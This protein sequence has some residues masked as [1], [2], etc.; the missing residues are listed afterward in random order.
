[1]DD[2]SPPN[3]P[4][5]VSADAVRANQFP[6]THWSAVLLAREA[7]S[8]AG[9]AALEQ[10]CKAYW[11]P[12][13][14]A[15]RR[16]ARDSEEARDLTQEFFARLLERNSLARLTPEGGRFR[17]WLLKAFESFRINEWH[18]AQAAKRGG[19]Q[20]VLALD[21]EDAEGRA[22][23]DPADPRTPEMIYERCWAEELMERVQARLADQFGGHPLGFDTLQGFLIRPARETRFA[24]TAARLSVT[25]AAL[26][27]VV[28]RFRQRLRE[29]FREEVEQTV[30]DP[31][32]VEDEM[33]HLWKVLS[34]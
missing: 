12:L 14:A 7:E 29:L 6:T 16:Q 34:E 22:G 32:E 19:G 27:A 10:L 20:Q 24:E 8:P 2:R 18:R 23:I 15:A 9:T 5:A 17:S 31:R 33:R 1:M 3:V 30:A 21:W 4:G 13:Y 28:F 11:R 26:K 25:E